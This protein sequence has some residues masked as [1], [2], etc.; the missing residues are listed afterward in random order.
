MTSSLCETD[1]QRSEEFLVLLSCLKSKVRKGKG[2]KNEVL[3]SSGVLRGNLCSSPGTE[4]RLGGTSGTEILAKYRCDV[5]PGPASPCHPAGAL[6]G[7]SVSWSPER[8]GQCRQRPP[9]RGSLGTVP[10]TPPKS[11]GGSLQRRPRSPR[12]VERRFAARRPEDRGHPHTPLVPAAGLIRLPV[13]LPSVTEDERLDLPV[14][15]AGSRLGALCCCLQGCLSAGRHRARSCG[16]RA[17]APCPRWQE[18][19]M[20]PW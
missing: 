15:A 12:S 10:P 13:A 11:P 5:E 8:H 19:L 4:T 7:V 9:R 18:G 17:A 14:L 6:E 20:A 16:R 3:N 2:G 1:E